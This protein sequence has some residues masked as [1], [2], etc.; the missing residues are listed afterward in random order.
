MPKP[1]Q[2]SNPKNRR[3]QEKQ[4]ASTLGTEKA[5]ARK[6][7]TGRVNAPNHDNPLSGKKP[8]DRHQ[9]GLEVA[10]KQKKRQNKK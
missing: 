3:K 7:L 9:H 10:A 1:Q 4:K 8:N 6:E 5:K 2:T